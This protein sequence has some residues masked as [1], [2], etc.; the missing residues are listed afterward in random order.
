MPRP[1]SAFG[2]FFGF[3]R[4]VARRLAA[5]LLHQA[6][7]AVVQADIGGIGGDLVE[8]LGD[9]A[10]VLVDGPLIVVQ[11]DDHALG[12]RGDVVQRFEADAVGEG[13]IAGER[14]DVLAAAGH[15]PRH[16]HA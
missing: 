13:G 3:A 6:G 9:R 11:H 8:I 16:G 4:N 5:K 1:T 7:G 14:D 12:L 2:G 15:V 10:D